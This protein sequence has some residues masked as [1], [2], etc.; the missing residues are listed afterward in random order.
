MLQNQRILVTLHVIELRTDLHKHCRGR[1][2]TTVSELPFI[3]MHGAGNDYVFV[4]GFVT[5]LPDDATAMVQRISDRHFG[6]GADG[7]VY[8]L[9]PSNDSSDVE[10]RMWNA[11]GSEGVMCGNAL[12]CIALWMRKAGR[13]SDTCK[14]ST[15]SGIVHTEVLGADSAN[16]RAQVCAHLPPPVF[17]TSEEQ[18]LD[19]ILLPAAS[20]AGLRFT[21]VSVGNPHAV[22]FVD[23]LSDHIVR[24]LGSRVAA[25]PRFPGGVNVEWVRVVSTSELEVRVYER[26]SGET[27][28]C[29]SGACAAVAASVR[30]GLTARNTSIDVR[31]PGGNLNVLWHNSEG[32]GDESLQLTGPAAISFQGIWQN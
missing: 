16:N 27:L 10:M 18:T 7:L 21:E 6:I 12:R 3:K 32:G 5:A 30:Q 23:E 2:A 20:R 9:P 8:M 13:T 28:A 24:Q 15:P 19:D 17:P 14:V 22:I 29:G 25:H 4:D 31:L 11:D 1:P 26:G